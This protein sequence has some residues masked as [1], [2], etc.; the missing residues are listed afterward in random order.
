[1]STVAPVALVALTVGLAAGFIIEKNVIPLI[2]KNC[3]EPAANFV[4]TFDGFKLKDPNNPGDFVQALASATFRHNMVIIDNDHKCQQP[5]GLK[6]IG[7]INCSSI[8]PCI[9]SGKMNLHVTQKAGF[10]NISELQKALSY[11]NS[12]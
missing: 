4:C 5:D 1:M 7:L 6:D 9:N 11:L 3:T 10:N 12:P 8:D 2:Q